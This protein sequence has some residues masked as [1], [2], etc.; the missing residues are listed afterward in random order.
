MLAPRSSLRQVLEERVPLSVAPSTTLRRGNSS[1]LHSLF[2]LPRPG[3]PS[4]PVSSILFG[5]HY[6]AYLEHIVTIH[7][8]THSMP[9]K[10]GKG[11]QLDT[12]TSTL[13]D[14][15]QNIDHD[16]PSNLSS[17]PAAV[18]PVSRVQGVAPIARTSSQ[19]STNLFNTPTRFVQI[20]TTT[21][22][23]SAISIH[24][25]YLLKM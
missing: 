24:V 16:A 3:Y 19:P 23:P 2:P 9:P 7:S 25:S 17:S 20:S 22:S 4:T 18:D 21:F 13:N 14:K 1:I 10:D 8:D 6:V 12:N 11:D 5:F 15:P